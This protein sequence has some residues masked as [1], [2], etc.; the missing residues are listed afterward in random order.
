MLGINLNVQDEGILIYCQEYSG[1]KNDPE[2]FFNLEERIKNFMDT[3][4]EAKIAYQV[5]DKDGG[6]TLILY[7]KVFV[8][9]DNAHFLVFFL[10]YFRTTVVLRFFE[11]VP[12]SSFEIKLL[13]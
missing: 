13:L 2:M 5:Y 9:I 12:K 7:Q 4:K 8:L 6:A 10:C 1:G 11:Y 3:H